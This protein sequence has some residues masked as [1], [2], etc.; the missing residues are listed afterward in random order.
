MRYVYPQTGYTLHQAFEDL[1][2]QHSRAEIE[3]RSEQQALSISR[4]H[5]VRSLAT[6]LEHTGPPARIGRYHKRWT[7]LAPE[8]RMDR[9]QEYLASECVPPA[10]QTRM[11]SEMMAVNLDLLM[12]RWAQKRGLVTEIPGLDLTGASPSQFRLKKPP[13]PRPV[14]PTFRKAG[15]GRPHCIDPQGCGA[16]CPESSPLRH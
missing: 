2:E 10:I 11:L 9:L 7:D 8:Q 4:L 13:R 1:L 14:N 6:A 5:A 15:E 12:V 16:H 3:I